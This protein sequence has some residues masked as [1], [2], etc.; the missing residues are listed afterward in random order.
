MQRFASRASPQLGRSTSASSRRRGRGRRSAAAMAAH[1]P[2]PRR[3]AARRPRDGVRD[4]RGAIAQSVRA[5]TLLEGSRAR[6][7]AM[8]LTVLFALG[9]RSCSRSRGSRP[10]A[11]SCF[12]APNSTTAHRVWLRSCIGLSLLR[13]VR[14]FADAPRGRRLARIGVLLAGR[15]ARSSSH[16]SR[17]EP[18][19]QVTRRRAFHH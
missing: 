9:T 14:T 18:R 13:A 8:A 5:H 3:D 17:K 6:C 19:D 4:R 1:Q 11:A 7:P 10:S 12:A 15:A 2:T 16:A